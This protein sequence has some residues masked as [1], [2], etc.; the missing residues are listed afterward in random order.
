MSDDSM[1]VARV[2]GS[3]VH[4]SDLARSPEHIAALRD[5]FHAAAVRRVV[6]DAAEAA[7]LEA[8]PSEL[9]QAANDYRTRH[10]L[11]RADETMRWLADQ[12][13]SPADLQAEVRY[14]L[15]RQKLEER[16]AGVQVERWFH[17][18]KSVFDTALLAHIVVTDEGVARELMAELSEGEVAFDELARR[19]SHDAESAAL[20]GVLPPV[21]RKA[22]R[23]QQQSH[24]FGATPGDVVG[25]FEVGGAWEIVRV[26]EVRRA[27]LTDSVRAEIR[28]NLFAEWLEQALAAHEV[29]LWPFCDGA[30]VPPRSSSAAV[31]RP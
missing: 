29:T 3:P 16:H 1:V 20:G 22:L 17:E 27:T 9:Q 23:P 26:L 5:V 13:L 11:G 14:L 12:G 28:E 21:R 15:L 4:L 18:H 25:P 8:S 2:D 6:A 24:I 19:H 10:G 31:S 7:H 30:A